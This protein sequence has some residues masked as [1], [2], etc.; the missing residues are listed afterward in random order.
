MPFEIA[1]NKA[2]ATLV[3][4]EA[5]LVYFKSRLLRYT[6]LVKG[7]YVAALTVEEY[8]RDVNTQEAQVLSDRADLAA[9]ELDL[10]H[11]YV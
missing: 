5:A 1:V 3:K 9:A 10:E 6:K 4:D 7:D 2:K 11:C 8:E